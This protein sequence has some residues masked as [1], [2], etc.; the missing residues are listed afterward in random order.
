MSGTNPIPPNTQ[1]VS[2]NMGD[3]LARQLADLARRSGMS[4]SRYCALILQQAAQTDTTIEV[5][6]RVVVKSGSVKRKN[7]PLGKQQEKVAG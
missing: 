3:D 4:R 1:N 5:E 6:R 7:R 2:I